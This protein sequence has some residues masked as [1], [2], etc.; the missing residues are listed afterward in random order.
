MGNMWYSYVTNPD[1]APDYKNPPTFDPL[2]GF[3]EGR[4]ERSTFVITFRSK[5][6]IIDL[7]VI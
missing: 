5:E 3:P 6:C 7:P 4:E 2:F 1:T